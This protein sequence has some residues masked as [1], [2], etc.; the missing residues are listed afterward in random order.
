MPRATV[1]K[2]SVPLSSYCVSWLPSACSGPPLI[3]LCEGQYRISKQPRDSP[4]FSPESGSS[5]Q[6]AGGQPLVMPAPW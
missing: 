5:P 2:G 4:Q 1:P 6:P 3:Y